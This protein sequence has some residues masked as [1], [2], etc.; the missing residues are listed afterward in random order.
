MRPYGGFVSGRPCGPFMISRMPGTVAQVGARG[1]GREEIRDER[2]RARRDVEHAGLRIERG[3]G[4][5]APPF[6]PGSWSVPC[7]SPGALSIIDGG[8]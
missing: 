1:I 3:A 7:L 6:E 4:P 5:R 8:V 2:H